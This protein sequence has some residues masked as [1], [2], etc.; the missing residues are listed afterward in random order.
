MG[1]IIAEQCM[2]GSV[3]CVKD[4]CNV[5]NIVYDISDIDSANEK[6]H[7]VAVDNFLYC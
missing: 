2:V 5:K 7:T 6:I 1:V 4:R 3:T